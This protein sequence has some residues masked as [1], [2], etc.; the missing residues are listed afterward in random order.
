MENV[1]ILGAGP[2]G[3]SAAINLSRNGY[4]VDVFEKNQDVGS[5]IKRNIQGLENWSDEQDVIEEFKK[6]NIKTN[7]V[8][9]PFKD[10]KITNCRESWDFS[11]QKPAFYL[12]NRGKEE[13][14]LDHGLKEQALDNGVNIRFGETKPLENVDIVAIGADPKYKFAVGKGI[15][16]ETDHE[17]TAVGLVNDYHALK[18]YS[19]LL[20]SNGYGCI[21]TVLFETFEDLNKS[22]KRTMDEFSANFNLNV[23]DPRKFSGFGSFSNQIIKNEN[24][25]LIGETA[26]FQDLL[27]GFGIRNA[28]R[29]GF[30]AA[31][32][33]LEGKD[34]KD[35]YKTVEKYFKPKLNSSIVN[36]FIWEKFASNNYS[37]ILNR[38]HKANDPLKYLNSFHNFNLLQKLTYPIALFYMKYRYPNLKL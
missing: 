29:S 36:R 12:V 33:I 14:S 20:V 8:F 26:G 6:M 37:I 30:M 19:Y 21:A 15:T 17:N 32:S 24:Q 2:A 10:L 16:F 27:W 3:L 28:V 11:C 22:F 1:K 9:E 25:M 38:L 23:K 35:Y 7:F 4:N 34:C 13:T 5:S 18:G 31:K